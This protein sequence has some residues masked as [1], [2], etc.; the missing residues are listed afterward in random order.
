MNGV[1]LNAAITKQGAN[2]W[3]TRVWW[4]K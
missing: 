3:V 4:D 2:N 1:N